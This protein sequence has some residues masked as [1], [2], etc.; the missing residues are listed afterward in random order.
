MPQPW[1]QYQS[2]VPEKQP[3]EVF[4][5]ASQAEQPGL[6]S[7]IGTD[8]AGR[9]AEGAQSERDYQAGKISLPE[10]MWQTATKIV[11][12]S[13]GDLMGETAKSLTPQSA[14]NAASRGAQYVANKL[15][16]VDP[17]TSDALLGMSNATSTL[18]KNHPQ[19]AKDI[20]GAAD[21]LNIIPAQQAIRTGVNVASKAPGMAKKMT[22]IVNSVPDIGINLRGIAGDTTS[23]VSPMAAMNIPTIGGASFARKVGSSVTDVAGAVRGT[24]DILSSA[25][26][27]DISGR[28]YGA[29][30]GAT[31][32]IPAADSNAILDKVTSHASRTAEGKTFAGDN[33][34][35]KTAAD[36]QRL[37]DQPLS[38]QGAMEIDSNLG[39]R[40][41]V[42]KRAGENGTVMRLQNMQNSFREG[43]FNSG[44]DGAQGGREGIQAWAAAM[45]MRDIERMEQIAASSDNPAKTMATQANNLLKSPL[46][47]WGYRPDEIAALRS[48]SRTG[49]LT[50]VLRVAGSRLGPIAGGAA[51]FATGGIPGMAAASAADYVASSLARGGATA[52]QGS[53][54]NAVKR[55]IGNRPEIAA[56]TA[57]G[58]GSQAPAALKML[59]Y[60]PQPTEMLAGNRG[61]VQ[62]DPTQQA[63]LNSYR[64]QLSAM[65]LTPD[66]LSVQARQTANRLLEK[67]GQSDLGKFVAK[68]ANTP[69]SGQ[70]FDIPTTEYSQAEVNRMLSNSDWNKLD[71]L[72]KQEISRQIEQAW[73][74]HQTPIAEM[75]LDAENSARSLAKPASVS[76][77]RVSITNQLEKARLKGG[78]LT[79]MGEALK[80][81]MQLPPAQAR[82]VL[83]SLKRAK[84]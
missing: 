26:L 78:D 66:V 39:D 33:V 24:G 48:A 16:A 34:V 60:K 83:Q 46:K 32:L 70:I 27:R 80:R 36:F 82:Q 42:A 5:G 19:A 54:L 62:L 50:D 35:D 28:G 3:W 7:R 67:Y 63:T 79:D 38:I 22:A 53:R 25:Q 68:N 75:M 57:A 18:A 40:I 74:G 17:Q 41:A 23:G 61:V 43:I 72:Q 4:G 15:D 52:L 81:A 20:E 21:L 9:L 51:G 2:A 47:S 71:A 10:S 12:G 59:E 64:S 84:P 58:D 37:R 1:E 56:M 8:L 30:S 73:Q 6:L 14:S 44:I 11:G 31:N 55:L 29:S 49:I 76:N 77:P 13:A 69:I 45:K 65:G